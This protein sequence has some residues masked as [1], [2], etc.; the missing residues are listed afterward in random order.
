MTK[1]AVRRNLFIEDFATAD[2]IQ[3]AI[4]SGGPGGNDE[5]PA[6]LKHGRR[7]NPI[8]RR[9]RLV[10]PDRLHSAVGLSLLWRRLRPAFICNWPRAATRLTREAL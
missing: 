8:L 10:Q 9:P 3:P 2:T 5:A 6:T 4:G 7:V 1:V